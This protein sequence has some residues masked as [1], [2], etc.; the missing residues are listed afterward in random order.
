MTINDYRMNSISHL[1]NNY[2]FQVLVSAGKS[3]DC[4][5]PEPL[6]ELFIIS[7]NFTSKR[8]P[9]LPAWQTNQFI[10]TSTNILIDLYSTPNNFL[11]KRTLFNI[12]TLIK[13]QLPLGEI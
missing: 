9:T 1:P 8:L 6:P 12:K 13:Y 11:Q 2:P 3:N 4:H 7:I 10:R 5:P